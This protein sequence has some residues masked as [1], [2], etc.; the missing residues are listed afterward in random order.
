M[1]HKE[2]SAEIRFRKFLLKNWIKSN[3][4]SYVFST[5]SGVSSR[6]FHFWWCGFVAF[7]NLEGKNASPKKEV[8]GV[9]LQ[10]FNLLNRCVASK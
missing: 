5:F 7:G 2:L 4:E 3:F 8:E 10:I 6:P 1:G 9:R